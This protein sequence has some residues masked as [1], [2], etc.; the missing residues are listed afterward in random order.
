MS[1]CSRNTLLLRFIYC[2]L[3]CFHS[4]I[5]I[6]AQRLPPYFEHYDVKNGLSS[7]IITLLFKDR[8]G[9]LWAG[10]N[11]GLNKFNGTGFEIF[12]KDI[13]NPN[14]IAGNFIKTIYEDAA[15]RIWIDAD[16]GK[17]SCM[18]YPMR[19]GR[20]FINYDL[21]GFFPS[22][23][24]TGVS[25]Y[26]FEDAKNQLFAYNEGG[27]LFRYD[28]VQ[29][30]F[31]SVIKKED[32]LSLQIRGSYLPVTNG[33]DEFYIVRSGEGVYSFNTQ[34]KK[35]RLVSDR[36]LNQ[37]LQSGSVLQFIQQK[38]GH[39]ILWLVSDKGYFTSFDF[40][41]GKS[42]QPVAMPYQPKEAI[43][44]AVINKEGKICLGKNS[45]GM[46]VYDTALKI[47]STINSPFEVPN[48]NR[49]AEIY[50]YL[51]DDNDIFWIGTRS[52]IYQQSPLMNMFENYTIKQRDSLYSYIINISSFF[53]TGNKL[54]I[55]T[56]NELS[57]LYDFT[58]NKLE[59]R[60]IKKEG[61]E[62]SA[63]NFIKSDNNG[64]FINTY[65]IQ[66]FNP[67]TGQLKKIQFQG[68]SASVRYFKDVRVHSILKDT[69]QGE[70]VWWLSGWLRPGWGVFL[71]HTKSK[72]VK[73]FV[74]KDGDKPFAPV[75]FRGIEKD[76]F[77]RIWAGTEGN[78]IVMIEN[79]ETGAHHV[80]RNIESDKNSLP[81]NIITDLC[82]D[83][84]G[85]IWVITSGGGIAK[86]EFIADKSP[87]FKTF[88]VKEGLQHLALYDAM[89]DKNNNI[90]ISSSA[91]IEK[92]NIR[93]FSFSHYGYDNGILNP[94]FA[95]GSYMDD[96][97]YFYFSSFFTFVRFY[98]DSVKDNFAA[99]AIKINRL[100]VM[101][102]DSSEL[103]LQNGVQLP[104]K[105][106]FLSFTL[107]A[108]SLAGIKNVRYRYMLKGFDKGWVEAGNRN[109]VTY[110]DISPGTYTFLFTASYNGITWNKQPAA[111]TFTI[112]PPWYQTWWFRIL[113]VVL[114]AGF[115]LFAVR[116]YTNR[117]LEKQ[118]ALLEKQKAIELERMRIS[119]ELH[120]DMGGELSAIR[121]LSEMNISTISP[122]QQLSKI[123]SSSGELVQKM[124]EI[125]WALNVSNDSLQG[126]IAYI[127]RYAVKHLDDVGIDC[128][129]KQPEKIPDI[130]VD[131]ITR[132]N[133]FL[134]VKEALNNVVKHANATEVKMSVTMDDSLQIII[135]D[136]GKGIPADMLQN[137]NGNGLRNMQQRVME[138]K[139][140][141]EITNHEGTTVQFNLP[142]SSSNTKR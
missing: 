90:W 25:L 68:D 10:T 137:R 103:L 142:V 101:N 134:L 15:G 46:L 74:L 7:N 32:S 69:I 133:I 125:V 76:R 120:D 21:S 85:N 109:Y 3:F 4:F 98:P 44:C 93:T 66:S 73:R 132:R 124:N 16:R 72:E 116:F 19:K 81:F 104:Y 53:K 106:N 11:N 34:N 26:F 100:Q 47:F 111:Y 5:F 94:Q 122:Q 14:S 119:T 8:K 140:V 9:Y 130:E 105:S 58:S 28:E 30:I 29:S 55:T 123:S 77:G 57:E 88:S 113:A 27:L 118:K 139:G 31:R 87:A 63:A 83:L 95:T 35:S 136:N 17:I 114:F 86:I 102:R 78:G 60:T 61:K 51:L 39:H 36:T 49:L 37:F 115:V 6:S 48:E 108:I 75:S 112:L 40:T 56:E 91:G 45:G 65:G 33:T 126:L 138:L 24:G 18:Q 84:D 70:E 89:V 38:A 52:G 121:L 107:E 96:E 82:K 1:R 135:H 13:A 129:F 110:P 54:W 42:L 131:G 23:D 50:T 59:V 80:Y 128:L 79:P 67:V 71:Y 64:F 99:P 12:R 43:R 2:S 62:I 127:R 92:F 141:M 20:E 97:G 41:T 22:S 117:K